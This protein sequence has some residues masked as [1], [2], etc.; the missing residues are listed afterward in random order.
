MKTVR[1]FLLLFLT[2]RGA[3]GGQVVINEFLAR[4]ALTVHDEFGEYDDWIELYNAGDDEVDLGGYYITDDLSN[5]TKW[6]LPE[7][8]EETEIPPHGYLLLWADDDSTQG[9][10]HLGFKLSGSGEQIGLFAPDG[11]TVVD[12]LT[13]GP[14]EQDISYGR[15]PD[16]SDN[17]FYFQQPTPGQCNESAGVSEKAPA[18]QIAPSSGFYTDSVLVELTAPAGDTIYYTLDS[19]EPDSQ[20]AVYTGSLNIRATTVL[21]ARVF[22]KGCLPSD[23]ITRNYLFNGSLH[24]PVVTLV[25]DPRNLWGDQGILDHRNAGWEKPVYI[26]YFDDTRQEV[27][28]L[29]GGIKIHAPDGR[30]QQSFRL[31]AKKKYGQECFDYSFFGQK[32]VHDFK[33]LVL[34]NGGNDGW[35]LKNGTGLRD[36]FIHILFARRGHA[37]AMAGYL[38][39]NVFLNG[40]YWGMYNLRERQDEDYI[41]SNYNYSGPMDLLERTLEESSTRNA[42]AGDWQAYDS[43]ESF[44]ANH[45]LSIAENYDY[46]CSQMD[47]D[48]FSDYWIFEIF[49][50]NFD[51]LSNNIKYWS[52]KAEQTVWRWLMWDVDHGIGLPF[53][54]NGVQYGD[55]NWNTLDWATGTEGPRVWGGSN[56]LIIRGLLT[57]PNYRNAFINRFCD[58]LNS[59]FS[60]DYTLNVLRQLKTAIEPD[61]PQQLARWGNNSFQEWQEN[62]TVME[63]YL[64][65]RPAVMYEYLKEKFELENS[66]RIL[67]QANTGG[68]IKINTLSVSAFP[69]QGSYFKNIPIVLSAQAD[70]GYLF[71]SW[72]LNGNEYS[73]SLQIHLKPLGDVTLSAVFEADTVPALI[74]NEIN[75]HSSASFD[76]EDWVEFFNPKRVAIDVS[77]WVFKDSDDQHAFVFPQNTMVDSLGYLVLCRN[78]DRFRQK[79][80][81]V[82][83][84]LGNMDFGLSGSGEKIRLYTDT[85][86]LM[87]EVEYD[88]N[89][90]WPTAADGGGYT[91]ELTEPNLDNS[92]AA[93]WAASRTIGGTP[94]RINSV[95]TALS[96]HPPQLAERC[97]LFQNYPNPFNPTTAIGFQLST[98]G[99]VDL[100]IYNVLGQK[101]AVLVSGKKPAGKYRVIWNATGFASGV[102][103]Y[104]LTVN[105]TL[106]QTKKMILMR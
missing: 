25:S 78:K 106:T 17:W 12:T 73:D 20:S 14:Q 58:L 76:T 49:A 101:M 103:I 55:V 52:P 40:Q 67:L 68:N 2:V 3:L 33:V 48:N 15:Q 83:P 53:A 99:K 10:L 91:L 23:I 63:N 41:Q 29:N 92:L 1:F 27:L 102:Y 59:Y 89:S 93:S 44:I 32:N 70:A 24:L 64:Q 100:S 62:V 22:K 51:W 18:P 104:R 42:I 105:G 84:L 50:G 19:S 79:F 45:D 75:Y 5:P 81:E 71:K 16:G 21:R 57:N 54:S 74:I 8:E 72:Q 98:A 66:Y 38:P 60:S 36:A 11:H 13:F 97:E 82:S 43:L 80:P 4:N 90:P 56:T 6:Q 47:V 46:V 30:A 88:D 26:E 28:D 86:E 9:A 94:G 31:Y 37:N 95:Y 96:H 39:V 77:G 35:Q 7:T 87:D 85:G 69:W 65:Q 61:V 34:R